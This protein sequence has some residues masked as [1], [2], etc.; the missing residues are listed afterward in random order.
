MHRIDT[1]G[2]Q[3]NRFSDGNPT[4]PTG[5]TGTIIDASWLNAVQ[6]EICGVIEALGGKPCKGLEYE[7]Q[8]A[9]VLKKSHQA[10][11]QRTEEKML[12]LRKKMIS[13]M[14][15]IKFGFLREIER[16]EMQTNRKKT[17][18]KEHHI[19]RLSF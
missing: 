13:Q 18:N 17:S 15:E 14:D 5:E 9:E 8:M 10:L 16:L 19:R 3:Q 11:E 2:H 12:D 6:E 4:D 1:Q 7:K